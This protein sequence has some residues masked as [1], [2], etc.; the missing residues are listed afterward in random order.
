M[1]GVKADLIRVERLSAVDIGHGYRNQ[2]DLGLRAAPDTVRS[3]TILFDRCWGRRQRG[4]RRDCGHDGVDA[5]LA[6][7]SQV[8][9]D[10]Q[11]VQDAAA[12]SGARSPGLSPVI[13]DVLVSPP[14]IQRS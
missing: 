14:D 12:R 9:T 8:S 13:V 1:I 5:K 4:E 10:V 6:A 11:S 7:V 3:P 2:L